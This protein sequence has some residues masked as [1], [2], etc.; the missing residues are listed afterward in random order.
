MSTGSRKIYKALSEKYG[1][2]ETD[3]KLAV[4]AAYDYMREE[5]LKFGNIK[6]VGVKGVFSL[7][8]RPG[9]IKDVETGEH[10]RLYNMLDYDEDVAPE[11]QKDKAIWN[12]YIRGDMEYLDYF[13]AKRKAEKEAKQ[14]ELL[15]EAI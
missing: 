13:R 8:P 11:N 5:I 2:G 7:R 9:Y 4:D 10:L 12:R 6:A 1:I 14:N 15:N 3:I